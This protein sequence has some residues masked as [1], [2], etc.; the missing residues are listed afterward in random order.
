MGTRN[1][2][3]ISKYE[4][5][6]AEENWNELFNLLNPKLFITPES[7]EL[8]AF[9]LLAKVAQILI[10]EDPIVPNNIKIACLKCL[11][12]SCYNSYIHKNY[13]STNIEQATYHKL[14]SMLA[15][16]ENLK[17]IQSSNS[18]PFDSHF[19]YEGVIEWAS[20][21]IT[22]CKINSVLLDEKL[23][24]L[25]LCIQ[26]L[27]NL[28]TCAYKDSS[29]PDCYNIPQYL[30]DTNLKGVIINITS[31]DHIQL[32]RASCI[33]I[34]NA[35][36]E[37]GEEV[38]TETEKTQIFSQLLKP[39]KDGFE[40]AREALMILLC[41]T[42]VLQSAYKNMTTENK[43]F[44]L[45][46][47]YNEV[48][49]ST[50]KS[51]EE[52]VFTDDTVIFLI[53]R[54]CRISDLIL[55]TV[56][57]YVGAYVD[58]IDPTEIVILHDILGILTSGS[59]KEYSIL[60]G[61]KSLLVNCTYLLKS[62]QIIGK[63][64][65]NYFTPLQK[66]SDVALAMQEA[67]NNEPETNSN[68]TKAKGNESETNSAESNLQ[69]HPAFGFKA[70]LIRII[71]NMSY[72]NKECQDLLREMEAVPLLLDCC[73]IDAR[74]PLIM[75]WT[76]LALRNLCEDNPANQEIIRNY[77]RV[78]VVENSVLQEMGVTLHEDEEGRKMGI[79]PLPREEKS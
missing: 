38:F 67:R 27:C 74:N 23:E 60:K 65:H 51:K 64:S 17:E 77:T 2:N 7:E 62:I 79:V 42:K 37:F 45:E 6:F 3:L 19:P 12:N 11:G 20:N 57:T 49:K 36:K 35:L 48:S 14:Y 78:G 68:S 61:Y 53:E 31:L 30:Y 8:I 56:D 16:N 28:F 47:I 43:L 22:S 44:L 33:F 46:L 15:N 58:E 29:F 73:N 71:G 21:F 59:Y 18:Y 24:I 52:Y 40:S 25:R 1:I 10:I 76:I 70:G 66:L 32:V 54:F 63:Q 26:F 13:A 39:I 55:K 9:P 75:Q 69:S 34:H 50:H 72:R 5:A 4:S 41:Q